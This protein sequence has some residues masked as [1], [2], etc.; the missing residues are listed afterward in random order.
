VAQLAIYINDALARRLDRA[1]KK[2]GVS[3]SRLVARL[4]ESHFADRLPDDFF[5]V[6]GSWE[7]DR[8]ADE[9]VADIRS[10]GRDAARPELD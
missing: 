9:I 3:R 4:L 5:A 7:D 8:S 10:A 1:A 2:A 6:L